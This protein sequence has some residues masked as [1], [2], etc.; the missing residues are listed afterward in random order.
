MTR[1]IL[2]SYKSWLQSYLKKLLAKI[3]QIGTPSILFLLSPLTFC[4]TFDRSSYSKYLF[5][6]VIL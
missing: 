3:M 2:L 4:I 6:Y 1:G 5:K